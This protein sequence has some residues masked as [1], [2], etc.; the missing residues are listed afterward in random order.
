MWI[1]SMGLEDVNINNLYDDARTGL[2][3]LKVIE[4]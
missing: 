4:K 1:N 2:S 3:L